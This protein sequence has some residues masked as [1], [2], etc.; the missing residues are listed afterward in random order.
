M[1]KSGCTECDTLPFKKHIVDCSRQDWHQHVSDS[2]RFTVYVTLQPGLRLQ[3]WLHNVNNKTILRDSLIIF[4]M[5][6]CDLETQICEHLGVALEFPPCVNLFSCPLVKYLRLEFSSL[7]NPTIILYSVLFTDASTLSFA[8][9]LY[10]R[11]EF[12]LCT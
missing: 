9:Y 12:L 3:P 8:R 6:V 2:W 11:K 4:H 10:S 7:W 5:A 1:C